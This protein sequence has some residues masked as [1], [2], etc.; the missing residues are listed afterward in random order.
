MK[1]FCCVV[2]N[3]IAFLE[4]NEFTN[5]IEMVT[6]C[7][8]IW[9][10]FE[11]RKRRHDASFGYYMILRH[12]IQRFKDL[13]SKEK[14]YKE[15]VDALYLLC[16]NTEMRKKGL[17]SEKHGE[18]LA[19]LSTKML[20]YLSSESNQ[21]P[22]YCCKKGKEKWKKDISNLISRLTTLDIY[23][24]NTSFYCWE[25]EKKVKEWH[26]ETIELLKSIEWQIRKK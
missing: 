9:G 18:M 3:G 8:V 7:I 21:V 23:F 11:V 16:Q 24:R 4:S 25:D 19:V 6:L 22:P 14:D 10:L 2:E 13:L 20:D 5:V 15:A 12:Y 26:T 1:C 17:G